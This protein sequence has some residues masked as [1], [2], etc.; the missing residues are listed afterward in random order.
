MKRILTISLLSI[1]GLAMSQQIR[2]AELQNGV[3]PK[4]EFSS[5][6][7][8]D[9]SIYKVGDKLKIGIPSNGPEFAAIRTGMMN[10]TPLLA[11][12]AGRETEIKTFFVIGNKSTGLYVHARTKAPTGLIG[13][14]IDL[15]NAIERGEVKS[16]GMTS[17]EALAELKKEKDKLDLGLISKEDFEKKKAELAPKIK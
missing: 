16:F 15:E 11:R 1:S 10:P 2:Y 4:G 13:Y 7:A 6:E 17:D 9:G 5:Y 12:E 14:G 3:K 8:K